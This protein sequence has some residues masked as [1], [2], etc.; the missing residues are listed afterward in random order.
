MGN[1]QE[2][3]FQEIESHIFQEVETFRRLNVSFFMKLK[4]SK[5]LFPTFGLFKNLLATSWI[6]K[7]VNFKRNRLFFQ[8]PFFHK[9]I[10]T[11][12]PEV[13]GDERTN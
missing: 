4:V 3:K 7:I 9:F 6:G 13:L 8:K 11:R 2:I 5:A 1:D 10:V 12:S